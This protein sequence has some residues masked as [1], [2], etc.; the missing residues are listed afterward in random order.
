MGEKGARLIR[1]KDILRTS[2]KKQSWLVVKLDPIC[3][4]GHESKLLTK[5]RLEP[6]RHDLAL[7]KQSL[8]FVK[9]GSFVKMSGK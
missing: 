6:I 9:L 3:K 7:V 2:S 4:D 5:L 8:R 1:R